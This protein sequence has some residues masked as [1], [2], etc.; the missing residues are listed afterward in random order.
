M[1]FTALVLPKREIMKKHDLIS[2]V[3]FFCFGLYISLYS[4]QF[5]LGGLHS[6]GSGFMPFL[7]GLIIC[8]FSAFIVLRA[9]F[10][11]TDHGEKIWSRVKLPKLVL[12]MLML[13]AYSFLLQPLGFF[14]CTFLLIFFLMRYLGLQTWR[15]T[16]LGALFSSTLSYLLFVTWLKVELPKGILGF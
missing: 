16:I 1:N 10:D 14:I 2:G 11:K 13:V 15:R 6:P 9:F 4:P 7:T 12:T 5:G 3:L 8:G